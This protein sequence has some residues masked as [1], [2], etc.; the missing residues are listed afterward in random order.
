MTR[1]PLIAAARIAALL[2]TALVLTGCAGLQAP[3]LPVVER[4]PVPVATGCVAGDRPAAPVPLRD[5]YDAAAW[6]A[7][8]PAQKAA[9][10]AAQALRHQNRGD[11]IAAATFACR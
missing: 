2:L 4:V 8:T 3:P 1:A 7:L 6:A 11:A 5:R 9:A 10:V